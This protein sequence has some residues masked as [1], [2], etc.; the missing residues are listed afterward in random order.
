MGVAFI[1][2]PDPTRREQQE[3][4]EEEEGPLKPC[5]HHC[6]DQ[7]Q[8]RPQHQSDPDPHQQHPVLVGLRDGETGHD[9]HEHE[10]VVDAQAVLGDVS[11]EEL[12]A[13]LTAVDGPQHQPEGDGDPDIEDH[14]PQGRAVGE[15][16]RAAIDDQEIE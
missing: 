7:D 5:Q 6:P 15:L 13:V 11:G 9:D 12:H 14:G 10:Q 3:G 2:A 16:V 4:P 1:P 8:E